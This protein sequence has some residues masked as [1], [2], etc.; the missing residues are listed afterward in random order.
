M[1]DFA[2]KSDSKKKN[3]ETSQFIDFAGNYDFKKNYSYLNGRLSTI[4]ENYKADVDK[5]NSKVAKN[6]NTWKNSDYYNDYQNQFTNNHSQITTLKQDLERYSEQ[7]KKALGEKKYQELTEY[8]SSVDSSYIEFD[9]SINQ[10]RKYYSQWKDEESYNRDYENY[11]YT[12]KYKGYSYSDLLKARADIETQVANDK[13]NDTLNRELSWLNTHKT[14]KQF[15]DTMTNDE[16][17]QYK[18]DYENKVKTLKD[19]IGNLNTE[20]LAHERGG[21]TYS[22]RYKT[23]VK[24]LESAEKELATLENN[25]GGVLY[26]D[27]AGAVTT[28]TLLKMRENESILSKINSDEKTKTAY[29]KAIEASKQIQTIDNKIMSEKIPSRDL[30]TEKQSQQAIIDEFEALGYN[31]DSLKHYEEWKTDRD[32]YA[33]TQAENMKYASEHPV[34]ATVE[35]I[36][37]A[38]F[39]PF[40]LADNM[41]DAKQY[42]LSNIYDDKIGMQ[43]ETYQGTVSKLIE[44][45]VYNKTDSEVLSWLASTAYSGVTSAAQSALTTAAC[46]VMFGGAGA[47]VA[48]AVMGTEAAA[49][50]YRTAISNGSSNEQ[51]IL[52][53]VTAGVGEALFEKIPLDNLLRLG[54]NASKETL[55]GVLKSIAKQG[56]LEGLEEGGTEIWNTLADGL[57]NGDRSAYNTSIRQYELQGYSIEEAVKKANNDWLNNLLSSVVGGFAGGISTGGVTGTGYAIGKVQENQNIKNTGK[58]ISATG[59]VNDLLTNAKGLEG[60]SEKETKTIN[61]LTSKIEGKTNANEHISSRDARYVGKLFNLVSEKQTENT[62]NLV[63]EEL[64]FHNADTSAETVDVLLKYAQGEKLTEAEQTVFDENKGAYVLDNI[65]HKMAQKSSKPTTET[66]DGVNADTFEGTTENAVENDFKQTTYNGE[67]ISFKYKSADAVELDNGETVSVEDITMSDDDAVFY[68]AIMGENDFFPEGRFVNGK[69]TSG[70]N[71]PAANAIRKI[72]GGTPTINQ[73]KGVQMYYN[74]GMYNI[75]RFGESGALTEAQE[76]QVFNLGRALSESVAEKESNTPKVKKYSKGKVKYNVKSEL[77]SRQQASVEVIEKLA[78]MF[79]ITFNLYESTLN[80]NG[81]RLSVMPNGE[82]TSANGYYMNGE[83]YV[84]INAGNNGQGAVL[85]TVAHELTHYIREGSPKKFKVLADFLVEQYESKGKSVDYYVNKQMEKARKSGNK[86]MKYSEAFEEFVAD[87]MEK[88]L[89][90][91]NAVEKLAMLR[92]K[93]KSVFD[94]LR[95]GIQ[96]LVDRIKQEYA[97]LTPDSAEGRTVATMTDVFSDIQDLFLEALDDA[98]NNFQKAEKNTDANDGV[99]MQVR[100]DFAQQLQDWRNGYGKPNGKYNGKYFDLGTTSDVLVK[101]GASNVKL[102]MYEDCLLKITGDKHSIALD[103][104]EKLPYE[105][106]D[107]VLLFKGSQPNSFVAL[108]EMLDKQGND[109]IVAIHINKKY[110]RNVINKIASIYSKS[111]DFGN[112]KINNYISQQI[113]KGNLIDASKNKASMW[114]TSRGLQLP[115]L[116]QTIIDANNSVPQENTTVNNNS[117]QENENNTQKKFSL[118]ENVEETKDLVA[119]HN[120]SAEKLLKSLNLGGLPMPSIAIM[121]AKDGHNQFGDISLVFRKDTIDPEADKSN[122]VYSGDA[123]T[124]TYPRTEYKV[125]E[126][127]ASKIYHRARSAG[128][129]TFFKPVHFHPDNIVDE[130]NSFGGIEGVINHYKND[131]SMK[132]FYLAETSEPIQ[133]IMGEE[134]NELSKQEIEQF[135]FVI[136]ALGKDNI[137]K[138]NTEGYSGRNWMQEFGEEYKTAL[139]KY[140]RTTAKASVTDEE[141]REIVESQKAYEHASN[142]KRIKKYIENGPV[143]V[144]PVQDYKATQRE[145]DNRV[146]QDEYIAW[147]TELFD[148]LVEKSGIRN[149]VDPYTNRGDKKSFEATHY[150][151]NLEN[152]VKAMKEQQ[153]V[154]NSFLFSGFSIWGV[155]SKRFNSIDEIKADSNRLVEYNEELFSEVKR[156]IGGKLTDIADTILNPRE[157]NYFIARDNAIDCILETI[158]TAKTRSGMLKQLKSYYALNQEMVTESLV[159]DIIDLVAEVQSMPTD[160][161]EAKPQRAVHFDEVAGVIM[162]SQESYEVDLTEIKNKL[163][164]YGVSIV[165]YTFGSNDE[166]IQALNSLEGVKF[167]ERGQSVYKLLGENQRLQKE[168]ERLKEK[169]K[170]LND[171]VK[172][173]RKITHG[174]IIDRTSTEAQARKIKKSTGSKIELSNLTDQLYAFYTLIIGSEDL[175]WDTVLTRAS[176]IANDILN[177]VPESTQ[178]DEYAQEILSY[179]RS[180]NI[181]LND[182]Q[183]AEV[184]NIYDSYNAYRKRLMGSITIS[185]KGTSLDSVWQDLA[186]QYPDTFSKDTNP[187]DMPLELADIIHT[188]RNSYEVIE[189]FD[190]TEQV[191]WLAE[192]IYDTYWDV[193]TVESVMDKLSKEHQ[194][195]INALKTQHAERVKKIYAK[196]QEDLKD[197]KA[198]YQEMYKRLRE[199]ATA[200]HKK[201]MLDYQ[202]KVHEAQ[203]K[204]IEKRNNT[205]TRR[206]ILKTLDKIDARLS[207]PTKEKNIGLEMQPLACRLL[208]LANLDTVDAD[209]RI[210]R[211][212]TEME[213]TTN[214]QVLNTLQTRIDNITKQGEKKAAELQQKRNKYKA[215]AADAQNSLQQMGKTVEID[216]VIDKTLKDIE[217]LVGGT[218][219]RR[220]TSYQLECLK[221]AVNM[222]DG[223]IRADKQLFIDGKKQDVENMAQTVIHEVLGNSKKEKQF[224]KQ[225]EWLNKFGWSMLKPETAFDLIG[226]SALSHLFQEARKGDDKFARSVS[227][228]QIFL[229]ENVKKYGADKWN[230]EERKEFMIQDEK[231]TLTLGEIL[232]LYAYSKRDQAIPHLESGGFVQVEPVKKKIGGKINIE[233]T[234]Y[235]DHAHRISEVELG[236]IINILTKEQIEFADVMQEYLS[237]VMGAKGNEISRE[238]YQIDLFKE[239]F[240]FPLKLSSVYKDFKKNENSKTPVLKNAGMTKPTVTNANDPIVLESFENVWT[241]HVVQMSRYNA[242]VLGIEN[243]TKVFGYTGID[244]SSVRAALQGTYGDAVIKYIENFIIDLNGGRKGMSHGDMVNVA[245]KLLSTFKKVTV[246]ASLSTAIQQPSSVIRAMSY[247]KPK[248][249]MMRSNEKISHK[250]NWEEL[251]KYAPIA[252]LKEIGGYDMSS[253]INVADFIKHR[254]Y[255]GKEK[256]T[257]FFKDSNYRDDI[258]MW[259]ASKGDELAWSTLWH[260]IKKEQRYRFPNMEKEKFLKI[261]G[262]RFTDIATKTQVYDSVFTRSEIMRSPSETNKMA[263]S[264]MGEPMTN[265]NIII[266][267]IVQAKRGKITRPQAVWNISCVYIAQISAAALASIVYAMR[268]DD[269]DE[270]FIE[271]YMSAFGNKVSDEILP[272]TWI[273]YVRDFY[274]LCQGYDVS[275]TDMSVLSD[276]VESFQNLTNNNISLDEK[277]TGVSGSVAA[278]FGVPLKNVIRDGKAVA[279]TIGMMFD[280]NVAKS[281]DGAKAFA[282]GIFGEKKMADANEYLSKD[283]TEKANKIIN[284]LLEEKT[285]KNISNGKTPEKAEKDAKSSIRSSL[286]S[287]WKP[288]FIKAYQ[289]DDYIEQEEIY[290]RLLSTGIYGTSGELKETIEKWVKDLQ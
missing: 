192:Q 160:Y 162:P 206:Q 234:V 212:N 211:L 161:F 289:E 256:I 143:E 27:E 99:K 65:V 194:Q 283:K 63:K 67:A 33:Q 200:S 255:K 24:D 141:I 11:T 21:Q 204:A 231:V 6:D 272:I 72:F 199:R 58:L 136:N 47:N 209:Y 142:V 185:Q 250:D 165:E 237:T 191:R 126:D 57:I 217:A 201:Q 233:Y 135:D 208:T 75:K 147:L 264:F 97:K 133:M 145:I 215:I 172:L 164:E 64:K 139:V 181:R 195:Q 173:Q 109:V 132:Q 230:M 267:S 225:L 153:D 95:E 138:L 166:R 17:I 78:D 87:S 286:T 5:Y 23:V 218:P 115:K 76:K 244:K 266:D 16:L 85:Y 180:K 261:C 129:T 125:N 189:E 193:S 98:S 248:Y 287:Y 269:D 104:L 26:Y 81:E 124:P 271:K 170:Y 273:P 94:K 259:G 249:F 274:S 179:I 127:V 83:I 277:I 15:A 151:E 280:D 227:A 196:H 184:E 40:E 7:Y 114:F 120:L 44:D 38:P 210:E 70:V 240:Y 73:L 171:F 34:L 246:S 14:D 163:S 175:V 46:T 236:S 205:E 35:S 8:V 91:Q 3:N 276:L 190:K 167:S 177:E 279:N 10:K 137:L 19:T 235:K 92:T 178:R 1:I 43:N 158:A 228:A 251:K 154:G 37:T 110:G 48:L 107:P 183:R 88:M 56:F 229:S 93:D 197:Q 278:M 61:K 241:N 174:K 157:S 226:S 176:W 4:G 60:L 86:N 2:G 148:G 96:K 222:V 257:A 52:T 100:E 32:N 187:A 54:K 220:M 223:Y 49:S 50:S 36:L 80:E 285:E 242:Y 219:I 12:N 203:A 90:D 116:V 69:L 168:N 39:T 159:Q 29:E 13:E 182:I 77:N 245:S 105:L 55:V 150:V 82:K 232:S 121:K 247:V 258:L 131:H 281:G 213:N 108:T 202:D 268:D 45:A 149:N 188:L 84:D 28:D 117:M 243:L 270:S 239:K 275:R 79:N 74:Y 128:E 20:K 111:D 22:E 263:T 282:E 59:G 30:T 224:I 198:Y 119:V 66:V 207:H 51:A 102:I 252:V 221:N 71:I 140:Y 101:H 144:T 284:D 146:N 253:G 155:A 186:E 262:Q 265:L 214:P 103:E 123:W 53:S 25:N 68:D 254:N 130:V 31:F 113:Q 260:A 288:L 122:K 89:T 169:V 134:R 41:S 18:E 106:D 9:N 216:E 62:R 238:L 156:S 290:E 42:G 118:R 152:V 112:N